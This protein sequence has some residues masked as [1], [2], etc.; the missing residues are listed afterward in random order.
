MR[1][2]LSISASWPWLGP[3]LILGLAIA[4]AAVTI[5][6]FKDVQD[7]MEGDLAQ[8]RQGAERKIN[9]AKR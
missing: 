9:E 3:V 7:E 4:C 6:I 8:R 5:E 2:V 1:I